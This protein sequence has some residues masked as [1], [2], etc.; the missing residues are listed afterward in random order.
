MAFLKLKM[1]MTSEC[2]DLVQWCMLLNCT[3]K[4][5]LLTLC[6]ETAVCF[7]TQLSVWVWLHSS[8]SLTQATRFR[9]Q[10]F[11]QTQTVYNNIC[12]HFLIPN[13]FT[14]LS[15]SI[16]FKISCLHKGCNIYDSKIRQTSSILLQGGLQCCSI[17]ACECWDCRHQT[18]LQIHELSIAH[19][20]SLCEC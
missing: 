13:F 10:N 4:L 11:N 3:L 18:L 1:P 8:H 9:I 17:T 5:Q 19:C 20:L 15:K 16:E 14:A 2:S 6:L 7:A 12:T